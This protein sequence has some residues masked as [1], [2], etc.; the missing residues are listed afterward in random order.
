MTKLGQKRTSKKK[1]LNKKSK[2]S[3]P[4]LKDK[5]WVV[6]S[7]YIRRRDCLATTGSIEYGECISCGT[8][9]PFSELDAGHFVPK[10]NG[11][12]FSEHG[13]NAQCQSCNRY[14][15]GMPLE[16]Q[17]ALIEKYGIEETKRLRDE[18]KVIKKFTVSELEELY[19]RYSKLLKELESKK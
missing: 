10:H 18:N 1:P 7:K 9:K 8:N 13:V 6:F 14:H 12:L 3:I 4:S 15:S 16:Y 11:N 2:R 5:V 17:D 19:E